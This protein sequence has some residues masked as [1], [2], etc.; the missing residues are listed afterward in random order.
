MTLQLVPPV[1]PKEVKSD[2][3]SRATAT[4]A[5]E[6]LRRATTN[7]IRAH[8][9]TAGACASRAYGTWMGAEQEELAFAPTKR[10]RVRPG[11]DR[12]RRDIDDKG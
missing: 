12:R 1:N 4:R 9:T 10:V 5:R 6:M 7:A 11:F 2:G 3:F 8:R